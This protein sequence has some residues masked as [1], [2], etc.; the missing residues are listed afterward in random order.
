MKYENGFSREKNETASPV[1]I[2]YKTLLF[3]Y[4]F[5]AYLKKKMGLV[6]EVAYLEFYTMCNSIQENYECFWSV[7]FS[8]ANRCILSTI[9]AQAWDDKQGLCSEF[10]TDLIKSNKLLQFKLGSYFIVSYIYI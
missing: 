7:T 8:I 9:T 4:V 3:I 2:A 1:V 5:I 10:E 6:E